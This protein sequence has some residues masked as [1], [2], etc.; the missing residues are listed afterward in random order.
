MGHIGLD[1]LSEWLQ[2]GTNPLPE[3][4]QME[5][6]GFSLIPAGSPPENPLELMQPDRLQSMLTRLGQQFDW[7]IIDPPPL[8]LLADPTVW[9]RLADGVLVVVREGKSEKKYLQRGLTPVDP[10]SLLGVVVNSCSNTDHKNYYSRY[11]VT[12]GP[13]V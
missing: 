8:L 9:A 4:Y 5:G 6:A 10:K 13:A 12:A 2:E 11:A 3:I 7:I 1:G